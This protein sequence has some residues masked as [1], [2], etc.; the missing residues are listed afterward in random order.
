MLYLKRGAALRREM[1]WLGSHRYL[2]VNVGGESLAEIEAAYAEIHRLLGFD[3]A[4]TGS[5]GVESPY[6]AEGI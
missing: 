4:G 2:V 6:V 5:Y 3:P 1:K